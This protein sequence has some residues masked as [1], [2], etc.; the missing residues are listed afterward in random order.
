MGGDHAN[1]VTV[2]EYFRST[3]FGKYV[4]RT[5]KEFVA[6]LKLQY[7]DLYPLD[8]PPGKLI[9]FAFRFADNYVIDVYT[10]ELRHTKRFSKDLQWNFE[11]FLQ[12]KISGIT[13]H[14]FGETPFNREFG[15]RKVH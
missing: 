10:Y 4:G 14:R 3:D 12:E 8:E 6:D 11:S 13:V 5:V 15:E 2:D 1:K 9:G 7:E